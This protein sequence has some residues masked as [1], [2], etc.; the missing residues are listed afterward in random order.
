MA[1]AEA[2]IAEEVRF[3]A[4]A[5]KLV[6]VE[7]DVRLESFKMVDRWLRGKGELSL[8]ECLKLWKVFICS[9]ETRAFFTQVSGWLTALRYSGSLP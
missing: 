3:A 5:R 6:D 8:A 1:E 4:M 7:Q 2:Q 9:G